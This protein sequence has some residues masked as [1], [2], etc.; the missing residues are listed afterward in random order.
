MRCSRRTW[1]PRTRPRRR[2]P[3]PRR[4]P[5]RPPRLPPRAARRHP[6]RRRRPPRLRRPPRRPPP[7]RRRRR[8]RLL[9]RRQARPGPPR[10]RREIHDRDQ[11]VLS[12]TDQPP[13]YAVHDPAT[14][15]WDLARAGHPQPALARPGHAAA[16]L[17]LPPGLPLG[18]DLGGGGHYQTPRVHTPRPS[19]LVPY[20]DGL[21]E[22]P[23]AAPDT[24]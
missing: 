18:A 4:R 20:T 11:H 14:G 23:A 19:T 7:R 16:F 15:D 10:R 22:N 6:P 3:P 17:D 12:V 9:R 21:I 8:P 24:R 2:R 1:S 13:V 5:R